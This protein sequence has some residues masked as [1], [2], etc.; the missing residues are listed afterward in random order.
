MILVDSS[1]WIDYFRGTA[2]AET[3]FLD[4][5]LGIESVAIGDIVLTEVLQ[6][7][8]TDASF[9]RARTL[10]AALELIDIG[11][12]TIALEAARNYR[13]LRTQGITVRKTID[14]LIA[15]RCIHDDLPLLFTDR[16]FQPFVDH[17]RLVS[18]LQ[19]KAGD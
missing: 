12:E 16:D 19:C 4:G 7:F 13:R 1:V 17:L 18:A 8:S 3:D 5:I 15:T 11:G 9:D 14:T 10:F 2:N 6:G